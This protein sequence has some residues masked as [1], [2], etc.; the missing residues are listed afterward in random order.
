YVGGTM[1]PAMEE[2]A[3]RYTKKTGRAVEIDYAGSGELLA[4]IEEQ[5]TGDLY[6]CHDP[7]LDI[8]MDRELGRDGWTVAALTPVIVVPDG[9]PK[10]IQGLRDLRQPGLSL[11]LTDY[12]YSTLGH[13]LPTIFRRAEMDFEALK[14]ENVRKTIK[15]G[16]QAANDVAIE[17]HDAALVWN[18]VAH[19]REDRLDA[20]EIPPAHLPRPEVDA[21][22]SASGKKWDMSTVRVTIATLGCSDQPA[23]AKDFAEFVAGADGAEVFE[24]YG[25]TIVPVKKEY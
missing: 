11:V 23:K 5:Q 12:R 18:A 14:T 4:R 25:F 19:L 2:L 6:V 17:R 16:G 20:V 9:N 24:E 21:I 15:S 10:G 7:F 8:L 13:M 1:R 22:S 3:R